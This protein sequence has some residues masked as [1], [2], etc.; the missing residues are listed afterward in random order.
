MNVDHKLLSLHL[1]TR[2]T[3][4]WSYT[5]LPCARTRLQLKPPPLVAT[6]HTQHTAGLQLSKH[7]GDARQSE[8]LMYKYPGDARLA[9]KGKVQSLVPP[10]SLAAAKTCLM[11]DHCTA[12]REPGRKMIS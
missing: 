1:I 4:S 12:R 11:F 6:V 5:G 3:G 8:E 10:P 2:L 9:S 7:R